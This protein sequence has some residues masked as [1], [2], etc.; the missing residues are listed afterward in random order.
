MAAAAH[1]ARPRDRRSSSALLPPTLW[2]G[3]VGRDRGACSRKTRKSFKREA[4]PTTQVTRERGKARLLRACEFTQNCSGYRSS[5]TD[6]VHHVEAAAKN[7]NYPST[8][9]IS[10]GC[11]HY[12]VFRRRRRRSMARGSGLG[13]ESPTSCDFTGCSTR[14]RLCTCETR[15]KRPNAKG[16]M[17]LPSANSEC[18]DVRRR[19]NGR[20]SRG[21]VYKR[22]KTG[23]CG[24]AHTLWRVKF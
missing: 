1:S 2:S 13:D 22:T 12:L 14:R 9:E 15:D 3:A 5:N 6:R 17:N 11:D 10:R 8:T 24:T 4:T 18:V 20:A 19:I 23:V 7:A 21:M 16:S